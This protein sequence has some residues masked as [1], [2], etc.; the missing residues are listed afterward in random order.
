SGKSGFGER[1]QLVRYVRILDDLHSLGL[2]LPAKACR[3]L[4]Y[5][6]PRDSLAEI[7]ESF[8]GSAAENPDRQRV[9][10]LPWQDIAQGAREPAG[11]VAEPGKTILTDV[12]RYLK[13]L[14]LEYFDGFN[15]WDGLPDFEADAGAFYAAPA[16]RFQGFTEERLLESLEARKGAWMP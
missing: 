15:P 6:T 7:E 9:F 5:L 14:S 11:R 13:R 1:D 4:L 2:N 12:A 10:R 3:S 16:T 8:P